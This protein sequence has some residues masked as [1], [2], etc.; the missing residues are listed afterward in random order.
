MKFTFDALFFRESLRGLAPRDLRCATTPRLYQVSYGD[1]SYTVGDGSYTVGDCISETL[2][3]NDAAS[4]DNIAHG[5]GHNIEGIF[6]GAAG[7]YKGV[8]T[9][10]L[11][12]LAPE[13]TAAMIASH[14]DYASVNLAARVVVSNLHKNTHVLLCGVGRGRG[15]VIPVAEAAVGSGGGGVIVDLG[16]AVTRL[17]TTVRDRFR[18]VRG[19]AGGGRGG[20]VPHALRSESAGERERAD[21]GLGFRWGKSVRLPARNYLV[22]KV[23]PLNMSI[24]LK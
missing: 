3:F 19:V 16:T 9:S 6:V 11:E 14:P 1:G 21:V 2:T 4:V 10:Q 7:V 23:P 24:I 20:A 13:T 12:E 17:E 8:T 18:G 22:L 5:C 15:E